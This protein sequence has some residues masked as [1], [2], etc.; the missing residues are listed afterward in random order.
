MSQYYNTHTPPRLQMVM[1]TNTNLDTSGLES[2][3]H[4]FSALDP[5]GVTGAGSTRE[6]VD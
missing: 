3:G 2:V 6:G 4:H 5:Y 1:G